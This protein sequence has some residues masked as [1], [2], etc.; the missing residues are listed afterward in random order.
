MCVHQSGFC[1]LG[2]V[3][4]CCASVCRK[5]GG[6]AKPQTPINKKTNA[7]RKGASRLAAMQAS[8]QT[9]AT[10]L[11]A[12]DGDRKEP[13][14]FTQVKPVRSSQQSVTVS[15]RMKHAPLKSNDIFGD[16]MAMGQGL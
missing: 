16:L 15:G 9:A 5:A 10:T 13:E 12:T 3:L 8:Q 11:P 7:Q 14:V 4:G 1:G 6:F 2:A